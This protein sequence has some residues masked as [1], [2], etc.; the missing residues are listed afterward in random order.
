MYS[1]GENLPGLR[2]APTTCQHS[3][4]QALATEMNVCAY[5]SVPEY[6]EDKY[7]PTSPCAEAL[8]DTVGAA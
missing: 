1:T 4:R 5:H 3:V 8:I 2:W 6:L 7:I